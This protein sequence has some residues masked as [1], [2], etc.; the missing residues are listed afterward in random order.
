ME[1]AARVGAGDLL[2]ERQELLVAV[3]GS[4]LVGDAPGR[5]LQRGEQGGGAVAGVVVGALLG[6]SRHTP[7][8][9]WVRSRAWIWDFSATHTTTA[10]SGGC[11]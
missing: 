9:G 11:R 10:R 6:A 5:D 4:A 1:L 3:A 8:T 2:E 7:R